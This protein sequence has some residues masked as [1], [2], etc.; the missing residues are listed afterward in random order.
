M[1]LGAAPWPHAAA[2]WVLIK[3][4]APAVD[5][6]VLTVS[7]SSSRVIN[8]GFLSDIRTHTLLLFY[9][10]FSKE[11]ADHEAYNERRLANYFAYQIRINYHIRSSYLRTT[12]ARDGTVLPLPSLLPMGCCRWER[13]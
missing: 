6:C 9:T 12:E 8:I 7:V 13:E 2:S 5:S 11:D 3:D 10:Q 1:V 4:S